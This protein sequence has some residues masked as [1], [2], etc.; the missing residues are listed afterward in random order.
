MRDEGWRF[1]RPVWES[2]TRGVGRAVY[3]ATGPER[4]YALVAFVHDLPDAMRSDR[5]I[6]TARD[7]TFALFDGMPT[8]DDLTRLQAKLPLQEAGRISPRAPNS[9]PRSRPRCSPSG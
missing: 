5:V 1:D 2:D 7:A 8:E 6:A 9:P 4:C 3:R